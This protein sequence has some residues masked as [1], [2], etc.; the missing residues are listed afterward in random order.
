VSGG[1]SMNERKPACALNGLL[2]CAFRPVA[3]Q[4]GNSEGRLRPSGPIG[5]RALTMKP[6]LSRSECIPATPGMWLI[7]PKAS[8]SMSSL[9]LAS[10]G[11]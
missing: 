5:N 6:M 11:Q 1:N 9:P 7:I 10:R 3:V 8:L 2:A 4:N